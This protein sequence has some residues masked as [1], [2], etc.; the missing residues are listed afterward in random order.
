MET[1]DYLN[2]IVNEIHTVVVATSDD[3]GL[4]ATSAIDMMDTD[5]EGLYFLTAKGKGFYDRLKNKSFIAFTGIKGE[6]TMS[7]I[8]VS[9]RGKVREIGYA[10]IPQLFEKNR[11]MYQ[12][13]PT[14]KSRQA[15]TVF[16]IYE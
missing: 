10:K 9:I 11:Y 3:D 8:A 2:Y 1:K 15:L 6:D 7:K 4:P 14:D 5:D 12:I 13:Y 16:Q